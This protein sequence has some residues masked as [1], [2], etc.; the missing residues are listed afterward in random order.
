MEVNFEEE[1]D[2][3]YASKDSYT[4]LLHKVASEQSQQADC[5]ASQP[6]VEEEQDYQG[7]FPQGK[8]HQAA[9]AQLVE[10][11]KALMEKSEKEYEGQP[12]Q[13]QASKAK[14][15]GKKK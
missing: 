3:Y 13:K 2:A 11:L 6:P 12:P 10:K 4:E 1:V 9:I 7:S 5:P 15:K 14:S 8:E